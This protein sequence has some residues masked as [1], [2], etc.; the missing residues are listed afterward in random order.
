MWS[1]RSRSCATA[2]SSPASWSARRRID[3][4]LFAVIMEAYVHGVSTR[5]VDD[6]VQA[7]GVDVGDLQ[8]RGVADLRRARRVAPG[9]PRPAARSRRV[10]LRVPRRHLRE[11]A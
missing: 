9:V 11:G 10:P 8:E 4:A 2:A 5:K 7:L 1:W 3:R 6:L